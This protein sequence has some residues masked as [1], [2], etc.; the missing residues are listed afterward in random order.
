MKAKANVVVT[1]VGNI[2]CRFFAKHYID[3]WRARVNA[4]LPYEYVT[5]DPV[6]KK[7]ISY[8]VH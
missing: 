6:K 2:T 3:V 1:K 4:R 8:S 5:M 7:V